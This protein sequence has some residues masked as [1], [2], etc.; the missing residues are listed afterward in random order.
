ML[1]AIARAAKAR[2]G[3]PPE[4]LAAWEADL[5]V[6][7]SDIARMV[8]FVAESV[9]AGRTTPV[10]VAA[11]ERRTDEWSLEHF[12]VTPSA[13]QRGVGRVLFA[14]VVDEVRENGGAVITILCD[15]NAVGFYERMGART[16]GAAPAPMPGAPE[17]V[18]PRL[19]LHLAKS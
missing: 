10:G 6:T 19:V 16:E 7:T 18:L 14:A 17:R 8:V 1:S 9:D 4:W 2:W 12:W 11:I 13:E 5:T 15:P 3:Y